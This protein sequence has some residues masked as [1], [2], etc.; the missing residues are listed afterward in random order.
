VMGGLRHVATDPQEQ[1]RG[2]ASALVRDTLHAMRGL[3]VPLSVLFPFS[4]RYYRKF[5]YELGGNHCHYWCRPT[6]IP[7]FV[8]RSLCRPATE[9]DLPE[10]S[11]LYERRARRSGCAMARSPRRWEQICSAPQH[12][13]LVAT[14]GPVEGYAVLEEARDSYGGKVMKV[15]DLSAETSRAWRGLLGYLSQSPVESVEWLAC[16][17][18]LASSGLLRSTAPLREGFKPRGIATVRPLFQL[19]VVDLEGTLNTLAGAFPAGPYRLA[20][21]ARDDLLTENSRPLTIQASGEEVEIRPARPSDPCLETDIR[22]LSQIISGY[23]SPGEAVSQELARCSSPAALET[24][25]MLFP[26]GNPFISELD[27]F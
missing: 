20:I 7:G 16:A 10:L 1:N 9:A 19:R 26:A 13:V 24:A 23:M 18:E 14:D 27:R 5:G 21:R 11:E 22:I 25:E 4:F 8:E 12:S 17:N 3:G 6:S 2:Y 15:L